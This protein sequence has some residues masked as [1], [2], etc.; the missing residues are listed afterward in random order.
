MEAVDKTERHS[1]P[2]ALKRINKE[3]LN[4]EAWYCS[5]LKELFR[6]LAVRVKSICIAMDGIEFREKVRS[7]VE[8]RT[9]SGG[10]STLI[11]CKNDD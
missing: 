7:I 4:E 5:Y 11:Y 2:E 1:N 8:T 10:K 9:D 6:E 3:N